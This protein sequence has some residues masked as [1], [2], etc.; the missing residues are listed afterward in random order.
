MPNRIIKESICCSQDIDDLKAE[1]EVFYYRLWVNCDD[2]GRFDARIQMLKS[3]L[4][5]LREQMKSN[6]IKRYLA[7]LESKGMVELYSVKGVL[8]GHVVAW[9][10]HQQIR[11]KR[12]KYPP[13]SDADNIGNQMISDDG[14]CH[15]NPIQSNPIRIQSESE[16]GD[17][18]PQIKF[19]QPTLEQVRDYC[20]ERNKGVDP[21]KWIDHY[22]SNGWM[23]G[24]NKMKDWKAAVRTWEKN[25]QSGNPFKDKLK[26]MMEDEQSRDNSNH[27]GYQGGLSKLLQEP[28]RD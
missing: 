20:K 13:I 11:A 6:D 5:P 4:Y 15:R 17:K 14:I 28:D 7:V 21:N 8:Y 24:K 22:T 19:T 9:E 1:E 27:V 25:V 18:P 12:S 26:E 16:S 10:S 23:V 2:Y 3:K